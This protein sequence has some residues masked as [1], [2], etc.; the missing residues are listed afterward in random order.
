MIEMCISPTGWI[1]ISIF[2]HESASRQN[3]MGI[4]RTSALFQKKYGSQPLTGRKES[5]SL[6]AVA[7]MYNEA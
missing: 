2:C 4:E 5:E 1:S 3:G 7:D 6:A